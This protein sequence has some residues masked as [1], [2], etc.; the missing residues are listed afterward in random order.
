MPGTG[1][2]K[3]VAWFGTLWRLTRW[4]WTRQAAGGSEIGG[5]NYRATDLGHVW[6]HCNMLPAKQKRNSLL[7]LPAKYA[8]LV[9]LGKDVAAR[10]QTKMDGRRRIRGAVRHSLDIRAGQGDKGESFS[11]LLQQAS[12]QSNK[13]TVPPPSLAATSFIKGVQVSSQ[14]LIEA[15][16]PSPNCRQGD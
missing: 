7:R 6:I 2:P 13:E 4:I 10:R 11:I 5:R 9:L 15:F 12:S 14:V 8:L 16:Q 1:D 3:K